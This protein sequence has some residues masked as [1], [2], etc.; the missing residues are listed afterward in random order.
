VADGSWGA[1]PGWK[2]GEGRL[3]MYGS[4]PR[5]SNP[6]PD[7]GSA[8]F[9][10]NIAQIPSPMQTTEPARVSPIVSGSISLNIITV[11]TR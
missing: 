8:H 11:S 9:E 2:G 10:L 6:G 7:P 3:P 1:A 5:R 4:G